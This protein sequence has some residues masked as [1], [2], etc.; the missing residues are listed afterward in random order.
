MQHMPDAGITPWCFGFVFQAP[1]ARWLLLRS[2]RMEESKLATP[3]SQITTGNNPG[4]QK[5]G[6]MEK[7]HAVPLLI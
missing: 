7:S 4:K 3:R 1:T 2:Q 5:L 6:K